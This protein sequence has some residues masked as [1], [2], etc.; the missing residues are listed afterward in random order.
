MGTTRA[1]SGF[2]ILK[3]EHLLAQMV[4]GGELMVNES[5]TDRLVANVHDL[6]THRWCT[7][8][9]TLDYGACMNGVL[10]YLDG[11]GRGTIATYVYKEPDPDDVEEFYLDAQ[12]ELDRW[13]SKVVNYDYSARPFS[14]PVFGGG[15]GCHNWFKMRDLRGDG[16]SI[17]DLETRDGVYRAER[18]S[19]LGTMR[20]DAKW[21][22][23][24]SRDGAWVECNTG[25]GEGNYGETTLLHGGG[26]TADNCLG[27]GIGSGNGHC[28]DDVLGEGYAN[29]VRQR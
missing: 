22:G 15:V 5:V 1:A 19:P 23:R 17:R 14:F 4:T 13:M 6:L 29:P 24:N 9:D 7:I 21:V 20:V 18:H 28:E 26:F 3:P 27:R 12:E 8:M 11:V 16:A 25:V 10:V 2:K